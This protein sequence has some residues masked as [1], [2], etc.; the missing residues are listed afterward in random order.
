MTKSTLPLILACLLF[1][2]VILYGQGLLP[3]ESGFWQ[4]ADN[5]SPQR[6]IRS[7]TAPDGRLYVISETNPH[8]F[9]SQD[10]GVS[11]KNIPVGSGDF[12]LNALTIAPN[13]DIYVAAKSSDK[14]FRSCDHGE[15]WQQLDAPMPKCQIQK[16]YIDGNNRIY[17]IARGDSG[18]N[19]Y[20]SSDD[21]MNWIQLGKSISC[22]LL[23]NGN[24][25]AGTSPESGDSDCD[26]AV[27]TDDGTTWQ[28][29]YRNWAYF[30]FSDLFMN[31]KGDLFAQCHEC[32][33][34]RT[35]N[36][37]IRS[38]DDG[39]SWQSIYGFSEESPILLDA[40][41]NLIIP[42]RSGFD[43]DGLAKSSDNGDSWIKL[44]VGG[45]N[46]V[47]DSTYNLLVF[48]S[49]DSGSAFYPIY[50]SSDLGLSWAP[51]HTGFGLADSPSQI[52][53]TPTG[54]IYAAAGRDLRKS[55]DLGKT[56]SYSTI[57][58]D[59]ANN[60]VTA[61]A[62]HPSGDLYAA[63]SNNGIYRSRNDGNQWQKVA[64][65]TA[66]S[67]FT[68]VVIDK[69]GTIF[70]VCCPTELYIRGTS[71]LFISTDD[72]ITWQCKTIN[73]DAPGI[74]QLV[75]M[76]EANMI[77][78]SDV[79]GNIYFS[80]NQ[81]DSWESERIPSVRQVF[82]MTYDEVSH[83][84][85]IMT[86]AG[87]YRRVNSSPSIWEKLQNDLPPSLAVASITYTKGML[88][89]S[90]REINMG[91]I[92]HFFYSS[93]HGAH[94]TKFAD[95]SSVFSNCGV[96]MAFHPAG[97]IFA[98]L[99]VEWSEFCTSDLFYCE[100]LFMNNADIPSGDQGSAASRH[101]LR[102]E[103]S[104]NYPNPFN[105]QTT[106]HYA[107]PMEEQV[108]L[109]LFD[110]TGRMVALLHD[111]M[112]PAGYHQLQVTGVNLASGVYFYRLTTGTFYKMI[113][114]TLLR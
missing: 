106:I 64:T 73:R 93:D 20:R 3:Q 1:S 76:D 43:R 111:G 86:D 53:V 71:L 85:I 72:G 46:V 83:Q 87:L 23:Q 84:L 9:C 7:A 63:T 54:V 94:W 42:D 30:E 62:W 19:C 27:S 70:S 4:F 82:S 103:L 38:L 41:D 28:E 77:A 40:A 80:A 10:G 95:N 11:W 33:E 18:I 60:H 49:P 109:E 55:M 2:A 102:Y 79:E 67:S 75:P 88:L 32:V 25:L 98:S 13:G 24:I 104:Q 5:T 69:R 14:L 90:C 48:G 99:G 96:S 61:L 56:W 108:R 92:Y 31:K 37:L 34:D 12:F 65:G 52:L 45:S 51:I 107:L 8:V 50:R 105:P 112:Q 114:M 22:L 57:M 89:A 74:Y 58:P 110:I 66:D 47:M 26:I 100:A 101:P 81:G 97:L 113:K 59:K 91:A 44:P 35:P 17:V 21:G 36:M 78:A 39:I 29:V 15:S 6:V 68:T 16:I